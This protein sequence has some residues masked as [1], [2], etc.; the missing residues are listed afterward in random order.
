VALSADAKTLVVGA[1]GYYLGTERTE[2]VKIYRADK[3][4]GDRVQLGET[5]YGDNAGDFFGKSVD[6]SCDGNT[7]AIG[8]TGYYEVNNLPGY[9]RVFSLELNDDLYTVSRKQISENW[10]LMR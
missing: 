3:D 10:T 8:S 9:V 5:I 1:P 7:F 2:Y 4:G 6:I